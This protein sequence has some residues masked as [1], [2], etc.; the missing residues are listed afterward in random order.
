MFLPS[1]KSIVTWLIIAWIFFA[2][3]WVYRY[4]L[5]TET[6]VWQGNRLSKQIDNL[7]SQITIEENAIIERDMVTKK[8]RRE[9]QKQVY[10]GWGKECSRYRRK[11]YRL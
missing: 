4:K 3:V 7:Q 1:K 9:N 6:W 11:D 8:M 10:W 2:F 5:M